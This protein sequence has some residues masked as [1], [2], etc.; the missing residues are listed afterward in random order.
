MSGEFPPTRYETT[1]MHKDGCRSFVEMNASVIMYKGKPA[2][3]V[4][5]RDINE[6]KRAE[7]T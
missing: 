7:A 6:R 2:D 1:L 4:V 5:V 3:L